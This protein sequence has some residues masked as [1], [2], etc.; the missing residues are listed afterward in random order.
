MPRR[1]VQK[2]RI[3]GRRFL[4]QS[5]GVRRPSMRE[6][7]IWV[8]A[9]GSGAGLREL[10]TRWWV[11]RSDGSEGGWAEADWIARI[12]AQRIRL[13]RSMVVRWGIMPILPYAGAPDGVKN[14]PDDTLED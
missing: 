2:A 4:C 11:R 9:P 6:G 5:S 1:R 12:V 14:R 13:W 7:M 10:V 3:S 8:S